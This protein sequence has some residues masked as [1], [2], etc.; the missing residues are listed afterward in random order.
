MSL[1]CYDPYFHCLVSEQSSLELLDHRAMLGQKK[2]LHIV[3]Q[4]LS[5]M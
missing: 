1:H 5:N 4:Q 2:C 3:T